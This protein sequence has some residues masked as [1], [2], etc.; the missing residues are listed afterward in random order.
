VKL[1][2]PDKLILELLREDAR[3]TVSE[4]AS[5][6]GVSR[7]TV[8]DRMERMQESGV[9]RRFTVDIDAERIEAPSGVRAMFDLRLR[10]N[11]CAIV[12]SSVKDWPEL[13]GCWSISGSTDMRILIEA[14]NQAEIE[15]LRDRLARHPDIAQLQ[16]TFVLKTWAERISGVRERVPEKYKIVVLEET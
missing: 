10:R 14:A 1:T 5:I 12:Y 6:V 9:I 15:R 16:T 7:P 8:R 11:V 4:I 13:V 2:E 3:R